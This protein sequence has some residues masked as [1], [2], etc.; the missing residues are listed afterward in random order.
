M[1]ER[2]L[3][4]R[5]WFP[6]RGERE[7]RPKL[8]PGSLKVEVGE[9]PGRVVGEVWFWHEGKIHTARTPHCFTQDLIWEL[10]VACEKLYDPAYFDGPQWADPNA[11]VG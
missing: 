7:Q 11:P 10:A 6:E 5:M 1:N 3:L 8:V 2:P 9:S 4:V